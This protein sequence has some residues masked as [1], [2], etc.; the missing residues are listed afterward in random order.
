MRE[1]PLCSYVTTPLKCK[2]PSYMFMHFTTMPLLYWQQTHEKYFILF[3]YQSKNKKSNS[4][5]QPL[6]AII[7]SY[8]LNKITTRGSVFRK[9][10]GAEM[11]FYFRLSLLS[12]LLINVL[13]C[14]LLSFF[15]HILQYTLYKL[16][17]L[18]NSLWFAINLFKTQC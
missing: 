10:L 11:R 6:I 17:T 16:D 4:L 5:L 7:C 8:E 2:I 3:T 9:Q 1:T 14:F 18:H 15:T 13:S 12:Q